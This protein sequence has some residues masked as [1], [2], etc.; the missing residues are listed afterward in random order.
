MDLFRQES[1]AI[2]SSARLC[3]GVDTYIRIIID[4]Y[5]SS[6]IDRRFW[7]TDRE[8]EFYIATIINILNGHLNPISEESIQ[9]YKK[10]FNNN[11]DKSKIS[12]YINRIRKKS[13]LKYNKRTK[14]VEVPP[15]FYGIDL[16]ND[17]IRFNLNFVYEQAD[18]SDTD[19]DSGQE[20]IVEDHPYSAR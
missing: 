19:G 4:I 7:L 3:R 20:Y 13:W 17:S 1:R 15:I 6:E 5:S 16:N 12:D 14:V 10:Y 11:T 18:R 8:K 9:I 2:A